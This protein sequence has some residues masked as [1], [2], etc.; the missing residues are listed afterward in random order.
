LY[1][2]VDNIGTL[3]FL[4]VKDITMILTMNNKDALALAISTT[5]ETLGS[6]IDKAS[7]D[8]I[9]LLFR[10]MA[11]VSDAL[12]QVGEP[13]SQFKTISELNTKFIPV[14][15]DELSGE[16]DRVVMKESNR[17]YAQALQYVIVKAK[18]PLPA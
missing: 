5:A 16:N 18:V 1:F 4:N 9:D 7:A 6:S 17:T 2:I 13:F 3:I 11:T 10:D 12:L 14:L 15:N 8:N